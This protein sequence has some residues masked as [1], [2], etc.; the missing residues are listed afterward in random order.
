MSIPGCPTRAAPRAGEGPFSVLSTPGGRCEAMAPAKVSTAP[1]HV[2]G[3][4]TTTVLP[5]S[6]DGIT[7]FPITAA[8]QLKG[9]MAATTPWGTRSMTVPASSRGWS[10]SATNSARAPTMPAVVAT[11]K[12]ASTRI[13]P[14]S[15][16]SSSEVDSRSIEPRARSQA[17]WRQDSRASNPTAAQPSWADRAAATAASSWSGEAAGACRTTSSGWAGLNT[18]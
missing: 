15:R 11:S 4:L 13:L 16:V 9:R 7:L 10:D 6:R 18:A 1:G 2:G 14:C 12:S 5:V 8:G 3:A 17:V